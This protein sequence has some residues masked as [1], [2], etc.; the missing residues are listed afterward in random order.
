MATGILRRRLGDWERLWFDPGQTVHAM[1][2]ALELDPGSVMVMV[3]GRRAAKDY[4]LRAGDE[5]R[6]LRL[7]TGG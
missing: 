3:N 7:I 4:V 5:V 2:L 1:L 6:L